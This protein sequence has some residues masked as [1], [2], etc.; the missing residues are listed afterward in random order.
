[1]KKI[2]EK[3][4]KNNLLAIF[5]F[6]IIL[7]GL[8]GFQNPIGGTVGRSNHGWLSSHGLTLAKN[9]SLKDHFLMFNSKYFYR[10]GDRVKVYLTG[11]IK[12][13]HQI[14]LEKDAV[15]Y[16]SYN[17]FPIFPFL[18]IKAAMLPFEPNLVLQIYVAGQIMNLFLFLSILFSV[19]IFRK[20]TN[21]FYQA[22]SIALVSFSSFYVLYYGDVIFHDI[23]ALFGFVLALYIFVKWEYANDQS[24]A[25]KKAMIF[26]V[27]LSMMMGWQP[28]TVFISWFLVDLSRCLF[29]KK[30]K[31]KN[32]I[33]QPSFFAL[34]LGLIFGGAILGAQLLNEWYMTHGMSRGNRGTLDSMRVRTGLLKGGYKEHIFGWPLFLKEELIYLYKII[35]PYPIFLYK[36]ATKNIFITIAIF[37]SLFQIIKRIFQKDQN[38]RLGILFVFIISGFIWHFLM[39]YHAGAHDF[40]AI[41]HIGIPLILYYGASF[42]IPR[43]LWGPIMVILLI[44]YLAGLHYINGKKRKAMLRSLSVTQEFQNIHNALPKESLILNPKARIG[45]S[46]HGHRFFLSGHYFTNFEN[47]EYI[48]SK[49]KPENTLQLTQNK[50]VNLYKIIKKEPNVD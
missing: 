30:I 34:S 39:R 16:G 24:S 27:A 4:E 13:P 43:R 31:F 14:R 33:K 26:P 37:L 22:L 49:E 35:I 38:F 7:F 32:L 18:I 20:L 12:S 44:I 42:W 6:A 29:F 17:R 47:A 10:Q 36:T 28:C 8:I 5:L 2:T 41:Y 46:P 25:N 3:F 45:Y 19:F 15:L 40:T 23:P 21:N 50:K 48:V 9:L 1:M 11:D